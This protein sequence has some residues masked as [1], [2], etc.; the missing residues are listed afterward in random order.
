MNELNVMPGNLIRSVLT[1]E[2]VVVDWLVIKHIQ[3]GNMQNIYDNSPIYEPIPLDEDILVKC[4]FTISRD[5]AHKVYNEF[6]NIFK[7]N[8]VKG[9]YYFTWGDCEISTIH[10]LQNLWADLIKTELTI[11]I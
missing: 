6:G 2:I 3:D 7:L 9:K 1:G 10:N 5:G 11:E 8:R 4:G